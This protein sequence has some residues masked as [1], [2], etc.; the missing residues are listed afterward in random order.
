MS[1]LDISLSLGNTRHDR[2]NKMNGGKFVESLPWYHNPH[3][4]R[5]QNQKGLGNPANQ[6]PQIFLFLLLS[7]LGFPKTPGGGGNKN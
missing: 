2:M 7:F 6:Q 5:Q 3:T 1:L 4:D